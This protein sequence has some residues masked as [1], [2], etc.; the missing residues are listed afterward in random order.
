MVQAVTVI[1]LLFVTYTTRSTIHLFEILLSACEALSNLP[2]RGI[3]LVA[4]KALD[5]PS[6]YCRWVMFRWVMFT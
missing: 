2:P 3:R 4:I 5:N 1:D 6:F